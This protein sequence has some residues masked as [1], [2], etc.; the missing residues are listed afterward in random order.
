MQFNKWWKTVVSFL[1]CT[2]L[3]VKGEIRTC[4]PILTAKCATHCRSFSL[5]NPHW[6]LYTTPAVWICGWRSLKQIILQSSFWLLKI[7]CNLL[8]L[9][10]LLLDFC[11]L[12]LVCS[13]I[14]PTKG[15]PNR[16]DFFSTAGTFSLTIRILFKNNLKRLSIQFSG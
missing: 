13:D 10:T 8:Q 6:N 7:T 5:H 15:R 9:N 4:S 16:R 2:I 1:G 3:L 12:V 14:V 11:N